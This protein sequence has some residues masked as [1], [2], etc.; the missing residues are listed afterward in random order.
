MRCG[1]LG[2]R[3]R[4]MQLNLHANAATTPKTRAY[5][6]ASP[7]SVTARCRAWHQPEDG[8]RWKSRSTTQDRTSRPKQINSSLSAVEEELVC[9]MRTRLDLALDDIVEVM[10]RCLNPKLW[11]SAIHRCLPWHGFSQRPKP[12]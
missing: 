4:T 11:R 10:R 2:P 6:Q 12:G 3:F 5:I 1:V 7:T 8:R 9:E